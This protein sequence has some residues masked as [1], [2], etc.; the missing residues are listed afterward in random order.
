MK[1]ILTKL[2]MIAGIKSDSKIALWLERFAF[3]FLILMTLSAPHSIAATQVSWLLGMIFWIA[4]FFVRPRLNFIKTSLF[5]PFLLFFLWSVFTSIFSYAPDIS[6]DKLRNTSLFFIFFFA[7]NNLRTL[8]AIKFIAF[9][10]I[11]SCM[12]N[13]IWTPIVR[14]IGRGVEIQNVK[15]ESPLIRS[16]LREGDT[17]LEVNGEKVHTPE[18]ILNNIKQKEISDITIY[19]PD[20]YATFQINQDDL[21]KGNALEQ[22]GVGAWKKSN[23]WRS[24]GF[25]GHYATYAEVLQLIGSLT[26]GLFVAGFS[27]QSRKQKT[28]DKVEK[29]KADS[30][31]FFRIVKSPIFLFL[32]VG[33]MALALLLTVTRASQLAFMISAA[34]IV[35]LGASRK[36][37]IISFLIAIPIMIGGLLFLQQSREVGFYDAKDGSITWRQT[38]YREGFELWTQNPRHFLIG[39][40]MDS[41]KRYKDEWGLFDNGKL[42]PGHFHSMPLQLVVERGLPALLLWL[43][44]LGVYGSKLFK[45]LRRKELNDWTEKGIILGS[46]GGLIGFFTSGIVHYNLGDGE[47]AMVF[48]LIM[49]LS[50][51]IIE[52]RPDGELKNNH[53]TA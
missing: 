41:I 14:L 10:L 47:V 22:L 53:A 33:L 50:M 19:R 49:S 36:M 32:C 17:I 37:I 51:G 42:P 48:Y 34:A 2:D 12:V 8:K 45:K 18:D 38:V 52:Y 29:N 13:V 24:A 16:E 20:Y 4:R 3:I 21:L 9:A 30:S 43:L 35:L 25:Y 1:D 31:T 5:V 26:L 27:R 23:N 44:I 15:A 46:F 6:L 28:S 7:I 11:L 39:V 40:G